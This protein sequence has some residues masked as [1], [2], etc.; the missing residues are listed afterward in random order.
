[1]T[2]VIIPD[3]RGSKE[4]TVLNKATGYD[5]FQQIPREEIIHDDT[6]GIY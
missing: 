6:Q 4:N 5:S 2:V 1:M 3:G